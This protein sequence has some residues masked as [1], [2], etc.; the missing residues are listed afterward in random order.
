MFKA[1]KGVVSIW[2]GCGTKKNVFDSYFE[3]SRG[4][5]GDED[6]PLNEFAKDA[7]ELFYDHDF[8]EAH[9]AGPKGKR[10]GDLLIRSFV[11]QVVR[12][13]WREESPAGRLRG[14]ELRLLDVRRYASSPLAG[15][16]N[17]RWYIGGCR[18]RS[19]LIRGRASG[20]P[21]HAHQ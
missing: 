5:P 16:S 19:P 18:T 3:E 11:R 6:V 15:R 7:G 14:R 12:G 2:L 1:E 17:R 13:R 9:W 20:R 8:V 4:W 10:T 21:P